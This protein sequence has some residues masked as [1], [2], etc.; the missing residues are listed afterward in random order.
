M[1]RFGGTS[2]GGGFVGNSTVSVHLEFENG[3]KV[4]YNNVKTLGVEFG[5]GFVQNNDVV[6][7]NT[8]DTNGSAVIKD[9]TGVGNGFIQNN[10]VILSGRDQAG[11]NES[12]AT[13][14]NTNAFGGEGYNGFVQNNNITISGGDFGQGFV[15]NNYDTMTPIDE[16]GNGFVQNNNIVLESEGSESHG[17]TST[18]DIVGMN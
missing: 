2:S 7:L 9:S 5:R 18:K 6:G 10:N 15:Q 17:F 14:T 13:D 3:S 16:L 4:S 11:N 12:K 8:L 1:I